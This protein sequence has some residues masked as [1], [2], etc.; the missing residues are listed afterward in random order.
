MSKSDNPH[1]WALV[2]LGVALG[3]FWA[4]MIF[5]AFGV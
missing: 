5:N 1:Q 3:A 4:V 2:L